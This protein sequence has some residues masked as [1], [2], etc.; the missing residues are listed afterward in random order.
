VAAGVLL[1]LYSVLR[2]LNRS[3]TVQLREDHG[4]WLEFAENAAPPPADPLVVR[5]RFGMYAAN[6]RANTDRIHSL[7]GDTEPHTVVWDLSEQPVLTSTVLDGL[8][9]ADT[10]LGEVRV[11]YAGLPADVDATA[12][13]W[14]WWGEVERQGRYFATVDEAVQAR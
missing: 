5:T 12:L 9:E 3:H 13:R 7:V 2:Q 11:V 10:D 8:R 6:L 1:T 4:H 14:L